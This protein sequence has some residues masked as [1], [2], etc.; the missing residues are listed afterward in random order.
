MKSGPIGEALEILQ[1]EVE[2]GVKT[3]AQQITA[4]QSQQVSQAQS[5]S[6]SG[7][8]PTQ[9]SS[10]QNTSVPSEQV[11]ASKPP[12]DPA[13]QFI[14]DLYGG[15]SPLIT[16]AEIKQ[17]ELEDKQKH[18]ELRQKLHSEYYQQL[19]NP[20]KPK[21]PHVQEKIEQEKQQDLVKLEEEDKKKPKALPIIAT[22]GMGT[23]EKFRG[24]SG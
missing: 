12:I 14:Q 21:E 5:K 24:V 20:S 16:E 6:Q 11:A 3:A 8:K 15:R 23:A 7:Q 19:V 18:E 13:K 17:K 4:K 10:D 22:K 2:Q 1:E 9:A